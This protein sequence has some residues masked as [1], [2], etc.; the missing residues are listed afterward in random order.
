MFITY[1]FLG[2]HEVAD[3]TTVEVS[4]IAVAV[5]T[6][7]FQGKEQRFLRETKGAAVSEQPP[8]LC[9]GIAD[10]SRSNERRNFLDVVIHSA[11]VMKT[12]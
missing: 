7:R 12:G 8:Y 6:L 5:V 2:H 9:I 10:T 4:D 1:S 11:K 3:A